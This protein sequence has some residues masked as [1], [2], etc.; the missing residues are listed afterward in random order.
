MLAS[1]LQTAI[2]I[3][4]AGLII[5]LGI[6]FVPRVGLAATTR[7]W[8][9][10]RGRILIEDALKAMLTANYEGQS[11][12]PSTLAGAL[13]L[14]Q[15]AALKLIKRLE[16][17][18]LIQSIHDALLLTRGGKDLAL[19]VL[20]AHRL[21]ERYLADEAGMPL[22]RVHKAADSAEHH[23]DQHKLDAL[24]EYLGHPQT[25]PHG[26]PIPAADGSYDPRRR[27]GLNDWPLNQ[28][29]RVVHVEDEP[30]EAMNQILAAGL[31]P[32]V[33]ITII[34]KDTKHIVFKTDGSE[35]SLPPALAARVHVRPVLEPARDPDGMIQLNELQIG[36]EAQVVCLS[37]QC[38]GLNRRRLMDLGLT[39]G[40]R[41]RAQ[42]TSALTSTRGYCV[43]DTLIAV[44]KE[45]AQQIFVNP[46]QTEK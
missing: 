7:R 26:D 22:S 20:R 33:I 5:L 34:A 9:T 2:S 19:H 28:P 17:K 25:D 12:T 21:W 6:V 16:A 30:P 35:Q 45:Q 43:R 38:R 46:F 44:R 40:A 1:Q 3:F 27:I 36:Q 32:E 31:R 10:L 23:L 42:L 39:P 14:G 15:Q 8:L 37:P 13:G 18:G 41:V 29:A 4:I 11:M 24:A